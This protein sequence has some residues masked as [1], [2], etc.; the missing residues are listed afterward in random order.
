MGAVMLLLP[1]VLAAVGLAVIILAFNDRVDARPDDGSARLPTRRERP[2]YHLHLQ[3][4][5]SVKPP[6]GS[7]TAGPGVT[8]L[9]RRR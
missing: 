4:R 3:I 8:K 6:S 7:R 1:L 2:L 5:S 9:P